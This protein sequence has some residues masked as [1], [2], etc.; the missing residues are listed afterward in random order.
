MS[1]SALFAMWKLVLPKLRHD[2]LEL[3]T[4]TVQPLHLLT[5]ATR[6]SLVIGQAMSAGV[7]AVFQVLVIVPIALLVGVR[8][9]PNPGYFSTDLG[10]IFLSSEG[11]A[12]LSM[13]AVSFLKTRERFMGIG[14]TLTF[15]LFLRATPFALWL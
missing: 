8:F 9:Y 11:F 14:Q 1:F 5:P 4:R 15:P 7:R 12:V 13:L 2:Q 3:Y 6:A 10:V